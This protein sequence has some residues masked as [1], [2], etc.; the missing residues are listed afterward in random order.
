MAGEKKPEKKQ[1]IRWGA[2]LWYIHL[3][4]LGV[5]ALW[6]TFT[7]AK[8]MTVFFTLFITM[9]GVLGV[10][11]GGHRLWAHRSFE[12][13]PL[14]KLFLVLAHTLAGVG[15]IYNWVLYHRVHH[16]FLGTDK[17]PYNHNRGLLYA[18][19]IANIKSPNVDKEQAQK[20]VDMRDME[21]DTLIWL[22]K[23]LY[24]LVFGI[25][26]LLLPL[27]APLE[28]WDESMANVVL[29]TGILRFAITANVAW[30]VNSALLIWGNDGNNDSIISVFVITKS[31]WPYYHY[32]VPWDWKTGEFG[33]YGTGCT[34][35]FLKIWNEMGFA[36]KMQTNTT[37][38]VREFLHDVATEKLSLEDGRYRLKEMAAYNALKAKLELKK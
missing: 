3:H 27:N 22:Q 12:A 37:E 36:S 34:M 2:V 10:T 5:Y 11:A 25:F 32:M 33:T 13:S 20:E 24:W 16:K 28:Y 29:I 26:G 31:N 17:D 8:W 15:P 38:D 1:D 30:L 14:L 23:E 21:S 18:H 19:Y 6:L 9:L 7:S 35:F 4:I